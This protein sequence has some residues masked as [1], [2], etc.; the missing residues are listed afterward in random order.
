M[1][2]LHTLPVCHSELEASAPK[3][4]SKLK[5]VCVKVGEQARFDVTVAA[6][7]DPDLKW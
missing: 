2:T 1:R 5:D 4:V 7:P 6:N 3:F